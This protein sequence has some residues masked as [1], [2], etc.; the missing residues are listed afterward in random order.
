M[1]GKHFG[2]ES[3]WGTCRRVMEFV[4]PETSFLYKF[5][6]LNAVKFH[7][8]KR[9][10]RKENLILKYHTVDSC[11]LNCS[12]C[13]TFSPLIENSFVD[14]NSF[15]NDIKQIT[16]LGNV[17]NLEFIGG[18]ALLHPNI[19][20][21]FDIARKYIQSGN[22][23]LV[24]N[25]ILLLKQ[26][27]LFW[28]SCKKNKIKIYITPYPI[29]LDYE[30]I[31]DIAEKYE[32]DLNYYYSGTK[33]FFVKTPLNIEG[34]ANVIKSFEKC[35]SSNCA[36]L[37]DGKLYSCYRPYCIR[38]FN[39]HYNKNFKVTENDYKDIYAVKDVNELLDFMCKAPPFCRYCY[40]QE[41]EF[42]IPWS[43]SKKDISEWMQV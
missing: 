43:V 7:S 11:N 2:F 41:M 8:K 16:I 30:K 35:M 25:G 37:R 39:E 38:F 26:D 3:F 22:L 28:E 13:S 29:K 20:D 33:S 24:S 1:K 15:E 21:L 12:G 31:T 9:N 14:K 10:K 34:R 27:T 5:F 18:E 40:M 32:I 17:E 42:G 19:L 23:V 4:L 36:T 6:Y